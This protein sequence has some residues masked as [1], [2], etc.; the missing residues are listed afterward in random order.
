MKHTLLSSLPQDHPWGKR[1]YCYDCLPSTNTLAKELAAK[2]A[3]EGMVIIAREQTGGRGRLGRNFSSPAGLGLYLSVILRPNCKPEKLMHLTCAAGVAS[4]D[5]IEKAIGFRPGIKWA[6]DLVWGKQKLGGILTELGFDTAGN[7]CW[8]V[9][10]IGI[11]CAHTPEDFPEDIRSVAASLS[12]AS[13]KAIAPMDLAERLIP[14]LAQMAENLFDAKEVMA[15][16]RCDC[17]TLGQNVCV[18]RGDT[19]RYGKALEV[20]D[21]GA[22]TVEFS[23]GHTETVTCGEVS[24]RGMYGYV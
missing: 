11:N 16:Y 21:D 10:G 3:Q 8:A 12:M 5:A 7:V 2:G 19:L 1:I 9:V 4:A 6:N 22:L 18:V 24:V 20:A 17:I 15:R 14:A 13:G 23:D